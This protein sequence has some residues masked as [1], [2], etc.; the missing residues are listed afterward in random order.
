[1]IVKGVLRIVQVES[2]EDNE[3]IKFFLGLVEDIKERDK[4][5]ITIRDT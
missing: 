3:S 5:N 4:S 2:E 1:M